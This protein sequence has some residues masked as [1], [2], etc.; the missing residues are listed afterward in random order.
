VAGSS[1]ISLR[2][3]SLIRGRAERSQGRDDECQHLFSQSRVHAHPEDLSHDEIR[4][5]EVTNLAHVNVE[6]SRLTKEV[7][8]EEQA[9]GDPPGK[10]PGAVC[11]TLR[12]TLL[13]GKGADDFDYVVEHLA[14]EAGVRPDKQG[15]SHDFVGPFEVSNDTKGLG[16]I[17]F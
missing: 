8:A 2:M 7:P 16:P 15:L 11:V 13:L 10:M 4:V 14:G 6:V 5:G 17:L 3:T 12:S 1:V 9:G